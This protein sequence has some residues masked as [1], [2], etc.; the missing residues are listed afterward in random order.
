MT[1][2]WSGSDFGFCAEISDL[3]K[4]QMTVSIDEAGVRWHSCATCS[5]TARVTSNLRSHVEAKHLGGL[6]Y[7]CHVC[8]NYPAKTWQTLLGHLRKEH[9]VTQYSV[10]T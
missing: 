9:G 8:R 5:F 10:G 6:M 2:G 7:Q 1:F 4:K 3:V